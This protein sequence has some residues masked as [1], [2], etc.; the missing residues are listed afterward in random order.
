MV[1]PFLRSSARALTIKAVRGTV[2]IKDIFGNEKGSQFLLRG[3]L[4]TL[5]RHRFPL[6]GDPFPLRAS[7]NCLIV[8]LRPG[9]FN[10]Q[11][12]GVSL[13]I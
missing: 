10:C 7:F 12:S 13:R 4:F 8:G 3:G 5:Q 11:D 2:A 6:R 1:W 9:D